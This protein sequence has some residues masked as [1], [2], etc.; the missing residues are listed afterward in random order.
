MSV[1]S[2]AP[3]AES[4]S[5]AASSAPV[6]PTQQQV[7]RFEQQLQQGGTPNEPSY[8]GAPPAGLEGDVHRLV[9]YLGEASTRINA[10]LGPVG[11]ESN[12]QGLPPELQ[13]QLQLQR[14][15]SEELR[16]MNNATLEFQLIGKSVDL[17]ENTPK[18]L[19]EQ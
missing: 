2:I 9:G 6:Q 17:A 8:Y 5:V 4:M 3:I 7:A 19:Y 18:V 1:G 11:I 13:Q 16:N 15:V 12:L 14:E 10:S